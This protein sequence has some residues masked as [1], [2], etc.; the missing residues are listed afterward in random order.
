LPGKV[1]TDVR[2]VLVIAADDVDL[3]ALLGQARIL[4]GHLDRDDG[5]GAAD[6]G[7]EA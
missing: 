3:P 7:V 4:D 1:D 6:V 2:L 5:I